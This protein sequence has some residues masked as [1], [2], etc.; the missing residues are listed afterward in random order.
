MI[1][2]PVSG[3]PIRREYYGVGFEIRHRSVCHEAFLARMKEVQ[4]PYPNFEDLDDETRMAINA[5]ALVGSVVTNHDDFADH[6]SA[7]YSFKGELTPEEAAHPEAKYFKNQTEML[8]VLDKQLR[9]WVYETYNNI[10]HFED[11]DRAEVIKK[12]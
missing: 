6:A 11:L 10:A 7:N 4:A 12:F 5:A 9:S 2:T 8:L 3:K 1:L